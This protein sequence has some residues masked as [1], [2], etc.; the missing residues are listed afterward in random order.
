MDEPVADI[1]PPQA[2]STIPANDLVAR[3]V[4]CPMCGYNLRGLIEPRCPECGF[5]FLWVELMDPARWV[6][7]YVFEHHPHR[8]VWSFFK[9]LIGGLWPGR[10][11]DS[12]TPSQPSRP[13]RLGVYCAITIVL[14]FC[15]TIAE[16][17]AS[18]VDAHAYVAGGRGTLGTWWRAV[19]FG[20]SNGPQ[21]GTLA[22][23][24]L[25]LPT[26][27]LLTYWTMMIF[28]TSMRIAKVNPIHV[29]RCII[30]C[31]DLCV[32]SG[33]FIAGAAATVP[34]W[35]SHYSRS[36]IIVPAL[37]ATLTSIIV[38]AYR[39]CQAYR[40][41]MRFHRP[42]ATVVATQLIV[43]LIAINI[44]AFWLASRW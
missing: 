1:S 8:N 9:T 36:T 38:F 18:A 39:M 17:V 25:A 19:R 26:W 24:A 27:S 5:T 10:F 21:I 7:A 12:L 34:V 40:L 20:T 43:G 11:W 30:Y 22:V 14:G 29:T 37:A 33:L 4:Q 6:H 28:G 41:Y 13:P 44:I 15:G 3:D 42:V 35:S 32:W 2:D 16:V 31:Q 23:L